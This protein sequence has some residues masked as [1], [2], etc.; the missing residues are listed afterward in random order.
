MKLAHQLIENLF[1]QIDKQANPI[2]CNDLNMIIDVCIHNQHKYGWIAFLRVNNR[3]CGAS[4][5][6]DIDDITKHD[7]YFF[8]EEALHYFIKKIRERSITDLVQGPTKLKI[9]G[10]NPAAPDYV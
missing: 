3:N 5:E 6:V 10:S 2:I 1:I 8:E 7:I 4:V 9:V